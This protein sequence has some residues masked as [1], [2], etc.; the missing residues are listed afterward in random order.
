MA[1]MTKSAVYVLD[2]SAMLQNPNIFYELGEYHDFGECHIYVPLATIKEIDGIKKG[3]DTRARHAREIARTLVRLRSCGNL[4]SGVQ[5]STGGILRVYDGYDDID[6]LASDVD[7]K[8]VGTAMKVKREIGKAI[9][10]LCTDSNMMTVCGSKGIKCEFWPFGVNWD[11]SNGMRPL[12]SVQTL[13]PS[14]WIKNKGHAKAANAKQ[15]MLIGAVMFIL[16][17]IIALAKH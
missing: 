3:S 17:L 4:E 16:I 7:N 10:I 6:A 9:T 15:G 1:R 11:L 14:P 2:T 12:A 8:V 5:L 13:R